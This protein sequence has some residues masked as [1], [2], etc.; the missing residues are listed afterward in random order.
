MA[1]PSRNAVQTNVQADQRTFFVT[2]CTSAKR[3]ILQSDRMR[4]LLLEV[5]MSYR[6]EHRYALHEFV[7]MSDH[8]HLLLTVDHDI[9]I[10]K[11]VGLIK[12]KF[13]Y[14]AGR[15][16]NWKG[17][18][19]EKGF[20]DHRVRDSE[21]YAGYVEYIHQNPVKAGMVNHPEQYEWSS[22]SGRLDLD[23]PPQRLKPF[24][25]EVTLRHR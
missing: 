19:W 12:G 10:E 23:S 15:E 25:T 21:Q 20:S 22:A 7:F 11:A 14:R 1:I 9:T 5:L 2:F 6:S 24:L 4:S 17:A 18:V 16:L 3:Q 8:V 13:S